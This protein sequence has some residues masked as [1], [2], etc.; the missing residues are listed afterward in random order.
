MTG[1]ERELREAAGTALGW[2]RSAVGAVEDAITGQLDHVPASWASA[3]RQVATA[4][5][6]LT[7]IPLPTEEVQ[8]LLEQLHAQRRSIE[9]VQAQLAALD[10]QLR[11]MEDSLHPL[12]VWVG[13]LQTLR[14]SLLHETETT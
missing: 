2:T 7:S 1:V 10:H 11:V 13:Q 4:L 6:A 9:A 3:T 8:V 5:E 14:D 12:E